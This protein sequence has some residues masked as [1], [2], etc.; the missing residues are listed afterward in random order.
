[1]ATD[2]EQERHRLMNVYSRMVDGEI[3][4]IAKDEASLTDV[5]RQVLHDEMARRGLDHLPPDR[6]GSQDEAAEDTEPEPMV[7]IPEQERHR[8]M[9]VYSRMFDDEIQGIAKDEASLTHV[10]RQVLR[11]EMARRGLDRLPPDRNGSQDEAAE[12]TEPMVT[13]RSFG[14]VLEQPV[15]EQPD[16]DNG[17][18]F[19]Y[20]GVLF[21]PAAFLLNF[22]VA[23]LST[24]NL[25][26]FARRLLRI[27]LPFSPLA[28]RE[29]L[30]C[31]VFPG[32]AA[33]C[34]SI[35]WATKTAKWV[36]IAPAFLLLVR[37]ALFPYAQVHRSVMEPPDDFWRHFFY[38]DLSK[39]YGD[40]GVTDFLF[41]SLSTVRACSYSFVA[42]ISGRWAPRLADNAIVI[43]MSDRPA[44]KT[45]RAIVSTPRWL[46]A[47]NLLIGMNVAVLALMA[48]SGV[49]LL[50]P[51]TDRLVQWG[52]SRGSLILHGQYWRLITQSFIHLGIFHL[53]QNMVC[54]W[55][56]GRLAERLF[57]GL[58]LIVIYSLTGIGAS[59]LSALSVPLRTS[60]GASGSILGI[61]GVLV[62]VVWYGRLR[63]P[64]SE[65]F[66]R[67]ISVFVFLFLISG[68]SPGVDNWAHAGGFA[69]GLL[70]GFWVARTLRMP[71][72]HTLFSAASLFQAREAIK[73]Q[74][75]ES[76]VEYLQ[77]YTQIRPDSADGHAL[78]GYSLDVLRR[79]AEAAKEYETAMNLGCADGAIEVNLAAIV[80]FKTKAA[81]Q[82]SV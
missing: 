9:N 41:F 33:F 23:E 10:A 54:L 50:S 13:I 30:L 31:V 72:P 71:T 24:G 3:Q 8:L 39:G 61:A 65:F 25:A 44:L 34:V 63:L 2:P 42:W 29:L 16:E 48:A 69:T 82:Q 12:D 15:P 59:L 67:R 64:P 17:S 43:P 26:V 1:M 53:T 79:S 49:S 38:P 62:V 46:T 45:P 68:L 70:L 78:L 14:D 28:E 19:D 20:S 18:I 47:T 4:G 5:A 55:W 77:A 57:G 74:A 22:I 76:A 21:G 36:W 56:I 51:G 60:A 11:D 6:N 75:H 7:T 52:A 40:P 58:V 35:F 81:N 27:Y 73:R 80:V 37:M 66:Y 32:V